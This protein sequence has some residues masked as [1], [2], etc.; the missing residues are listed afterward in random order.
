VNKLHFLISLIALFTVSQFALGQT[1]YETY[2]NGRFGYT[3]QYPSDLLRIQPA[4]FNGD[5]RVFISRDKNVEMRAW[6]NFNATFL[7]VEGQFDEDVKNYRGITYKHLFNNSFVI[8]GAQNGKVFYQKTLYHKFKET[9]VFYTFTI[10][11]PKTQKS[12]FDAI[13]TRISNSFKFDPN[14]EP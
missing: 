13:V 3:I 10:E 12:Q 5:G 6:A 4:P 2:S 1:K 9:E 14:A 11:Y 7:S 8:S